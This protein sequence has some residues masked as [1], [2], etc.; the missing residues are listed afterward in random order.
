MQIFTSKT[1]LSAYLSTLPKEQIIGFT[2]TMGALHDGHLSLI[3]ASNKKCDIT[4]C[5]IFVNP[6]QFN[7][8]EDL[9]NY[10]N[11]LNADLALL[12]KANCDIAYAPQFSDMYNN[13][14]IVKKY[15]FGDIATT[16]EGKYRPGHFNGM[17][18]VVEKFFTLIKPSTAFFG[19]KDLQQL[20]I[21]KALVKQMKTAPEII[22]VPTK[23]EESGLAKSSRN[24]LLSNFDKQQAALLYKCLVYCK[25]NKNQGIAKLK[26][27]ICETITSNKK[28]ELEY[29]EFVALKNMQAIQNWEEKDENAICIAAYISGVRL[30]DNII[31]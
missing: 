7:N 6:T 27:Y 30:I 20:Q 5:S 26:Q 17:A 18:T 22:S 11:T 29:V 24:K 10:P 23:R 12:K 25:N 1:E 28:F 14:E 13:G 3:T 4:I 16:M 19:Q 8:K 31:L 21:V 9:V 15:N 2:P